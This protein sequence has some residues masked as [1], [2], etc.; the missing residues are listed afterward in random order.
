MAKLFIKQ[1]NAAGE[2]VFFCLE[3]LLARLTGELLL[4]DN[5]W[6]WRYCKQYQHTD[7]QAEG[8]MADGLQ[9]LASLLEDLLV[10][11]GENLDAYQE[12]T[13]DL[14]L[15]LVDFNAIF[16]VQLE[17][18][19]RKIYQQLRANQRLVLA[20]ALQATYQQLCLRKEL[21]ERYQKQHML[22]GYSL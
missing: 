5:W 6:V 12:I 7:Y 8:R 21:Q 17:V 2:E 10:K 9:L 16:K 13:P 4:S 11:E 19:S 20:Y 18:M 15:D 3:K 1:I 22:V 14:V